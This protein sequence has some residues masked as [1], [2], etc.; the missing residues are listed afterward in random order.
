MNFK[1]AVKILNAHKKWLRGKGKKYVALDVTQGDEVLKSI[2]DAIDTVASMSKMMMP[3]EDFITLIEAASLTW[4]N[5]K[6]DPAN[7][8]A[9]K[10]ATK[11]A[12]YLLS[13]D[14]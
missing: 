7:K 13:K 9:K 1:D 10:M 4:A 3:R 8:S 2:C 5:G 12:M 14:K 6:L 11:I